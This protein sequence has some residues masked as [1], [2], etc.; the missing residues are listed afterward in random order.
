M[1]SVHYS[2]NSDEWETPQDFFNYWYN[3][4]KF[5]IDVC[6]SKENAKLDVYYD[7]SCNGLIK[8]WHGTAWCNPPYSNVKEWVLKAYREKLLGVTTVM[9]IPA[10]TDTKIWHDV[11]FPHAK[12]EFIKGR[13]KFSNSKNSAPFPSAIVIFYGAKQ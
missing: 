2:S 3:I 10:R 12:V 11:I 6:A 1:N 7:K 8:P 5:D 4:F 13:L 9:L